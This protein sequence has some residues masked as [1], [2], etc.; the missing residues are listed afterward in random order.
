MAVS[1]H[2]TELRHRPGQRDETGQQVHE[3]QPDV[4]MAAAHL[5]LQHRHPEALQGRRG[6]WT[7]AHPIRL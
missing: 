7:Q 6:R 1:P 3:Q 5:H 4:L 2:A